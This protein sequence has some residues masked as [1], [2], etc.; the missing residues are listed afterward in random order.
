MLTN[1]NDLRECAIEATD[2]NIGHI[3]DF[4]FDDET[5]VIRYFVVNTGSWLSSRKVLITPAAVKHA[6]WKNRILSVALT[7]EQVKSSPDIDTDKPVSRQHE[8]A[9]LS[10]YG[11]PAY[12]TGALTMTGH[13]SVAPVAANDYEEADNFRDVDEIKHRDDDHHLRSCKAISGYHIEAIDGDIGHVED[14]L[15]DEE[16]WA[17]RYFIVN[18]SNWWLGHSVLIAP[19]W[20]K[21]I[22]WATE[23]VAVDL[24]QKAIQKAPLYTAMAKLDR[25]QELEIYKHYGRVAYWE[26]TQDEQHEQH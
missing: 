13:S 3:S 6:N 20:I 8:K 10:H 26:N 17:L 14:I 21:S 18:T 25:A 23:K 1:L 16:T 9:N 19:Q 12:W 11:Y 4:Y 24:D 5:W 2:G 22:S 15:V 7:R